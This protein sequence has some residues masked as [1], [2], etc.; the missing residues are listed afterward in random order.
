VQRVE[1]YIVD[2]G[3]IK[4]KYD[5]NPQSSSFWGYFRLGYVSD[6]ERGLCKIIR[7]YESGEEEVL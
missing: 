1:G 6:W 2:Y 7:V 3:N 4:Y 5:M